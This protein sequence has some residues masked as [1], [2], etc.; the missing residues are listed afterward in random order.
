MALVRTEAGQEHKRAQATAAIDAGIHLAKRAALKRNEQ[1]RAQATA[2]MRAQATA[3]IDAGIRLAKR[4][5]LKKEMQEFDGA[6][7]TE[8]A[9]EVKAAAHQGLD[10]KLVSKSWKS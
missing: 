8:T 9:A 6:E 4:A 1:L 2:T 10:L 7:K 5:A 3:T